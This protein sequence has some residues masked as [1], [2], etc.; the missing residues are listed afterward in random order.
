MT[1]KPVFDVTKPEAQAL[2]VGGVVVGAIIA[3]WGAKHFFVEGLT[4]KERKNFLMFA[5]S[6]LGVVGANE[7]LDLD[8]VWYLT[9]ETILKKIDQEVSK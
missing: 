1:K 5:A 2:I 6:I 4:D 7:L 8:K 9:P 3:S